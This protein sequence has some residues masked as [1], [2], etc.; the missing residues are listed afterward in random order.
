VLAEQTAADQAVDQASAAFDS[1]GKS[2]QIADNFVLVAVIFA[3]VLFVAGIASRFQQHRIR[4][5][6]AILAALLF[7]VGA[8]AEFVLPQDFGL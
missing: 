8:V 2:N 7:A 3:S 1:A 6:L 4:T 5:G